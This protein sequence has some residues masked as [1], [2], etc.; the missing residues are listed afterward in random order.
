MAARET[1]LA[2]GGSIKAQ[3][4]GHELVGRIALLLQQLAHEPQGRRRVALGLDQQIQHLA[5]TVDSTPQVHARALDRDHHFVQ[6]PPARWP[7]SKPAQVAGEGGAELQDP[8]PD[9]LVGGFDAP[10]S[11]ELFHIAVAESEP[12]VEPRCMSDYLGWELMASVRDGLHGADRP[13]LGGPG[14]MLVQ[15]WPF[16]HGQPGRQSW[17]GERRRPGCEGGHEQLRSRRP[18]AQRSMR[19]HAVG[20]L[21]PALDHNFGLPQR[22]E[23]LSIQQFVSQ[24]TSVTPIERI[25]SATLRPCQT[26]TSTWRSL[27]TISSGLCLFLTRDP[28]SFSSHEPYFKADHFKGGGSRLSHSLNLSHHSGGSFFCVTFGTNHRRSWWLSFSA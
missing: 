13:P 25:A 21:S 7:G 19:P 2:S 18:V 16:H 9:G 1:Q 12:E 3:L 17:S 15:R 5:L 22:V 14:L 27:A 4:I 24:P 11:Q 10:L 28:S 23:N 8:A 20:V 26:S 6:V